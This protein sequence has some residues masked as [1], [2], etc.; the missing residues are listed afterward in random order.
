MEPAGSR[1][2]LEVIGE[3]D[4]SKADLFDQG[5]HVDHPLVSGLFLAT[6]CDGRSGA[7]FIELLELRSQGLSRDLLDRRVTLFTLS[8]SLFCATRVNNTIDL[9]QMYPAKP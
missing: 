2:A 3:P 1:R 9:T 6:N 4:V 5:D 7:P 8:S